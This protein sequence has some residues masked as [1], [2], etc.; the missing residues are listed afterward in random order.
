MYHPVQDRLQVLRQW[1][2]QNEDA[3][4]CEATLILKKKSLLRV[5][6]NE[7]LLTVEQMFVFRPHRTWNNCCLKRRLL[8][9]K[10]GLEMFVFLN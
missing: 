1:V 2:T 4:Q 7:E 10:A 8:L 5:E 9:C 6:G 3:S